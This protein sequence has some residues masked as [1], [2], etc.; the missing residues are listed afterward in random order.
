MQRFVPG[1]AVK[2]HFSGNHSTGRFRCRQEFETAGMG[3]SFYRAELSLKF[4]G[5]LRRR[6]CRFLTGVRLASR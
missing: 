3:C 1:H 6:W 4:D 5:K 2:F